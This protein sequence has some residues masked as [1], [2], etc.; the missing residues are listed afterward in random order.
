MC[1]NF[2]RNDSP[3]LQI[4]LNIGEFTLEKNPMYVN[5]AI[6]LLYGINLLENIKTRRLFSIVVCFT[7]QAVYYILLR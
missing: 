3:I 5:F 6:K 7:N 4:L 2:V 1:V